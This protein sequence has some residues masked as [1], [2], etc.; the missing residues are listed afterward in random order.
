MSDYAVED[1]RVAFAGQLSTIRVDRL[2]MPDG[3]VA[4]REIVEH[5]N[6]VAVVP[7]DGDG[8]V[9]LLRQYRHALGEHQ[10]EIP[11]GKLDVE[12]EA[13]EG[14]A[15]RELIE[16][17]GLDAGE[18]TQLVHFAN[19]AGWTTEHTTV[20]LATGLTAAD[21][22]DGFVSEAEEADMEVLRMPLADAIAQAERGEI[23]DSK[24]LIGLLLAR[25][26]LR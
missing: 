18:F 3:G 25:R 1:S 14:A 19:S 4:E 24:T 7:V 9:V 23:A 17:V 2:R 13:P 22:P 6:A 16:E 21:V 26:A 15:R 10:V 20:Y 12:G 11:A 5:S 8:N